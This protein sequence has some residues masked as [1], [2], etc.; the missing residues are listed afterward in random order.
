VSRLAGVI[1]ACVC[2]NDQPALPPTRTP[3]LSIASFEIG[4]KLG[5]GKFGRVYLART[6]AKPHFIVALKLLWKHEIVKDKVER[7]VRR[8]IEIQ[9]NLRHPNILRLYAYFHDT[10]RI[11]L[12][13]EYAIKG[14]LFK[15]LQREGRFSEKK[16]SRVGVLCGER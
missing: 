16:S 6:K 15:H 1:L 11:F 12:V 3:S 8:E 4:R 14:E 7:Q 5:R 9:Q 10:K 13:L 2:P